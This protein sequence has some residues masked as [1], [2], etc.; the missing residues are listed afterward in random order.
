PMRCSTRIAVSPNGQHFIASGLP[1]SDDTPTVTRVY[2][3]A[4]GQPGGPDLSAN[5][6][7]LHAALAP[8]RPFAALAVNSARPVVPGITSVQLWNWRSGAAIGTPLTVPSEPRAVAFSPDVAR[9]AVVCRGGQVAMI[10]VGAWHV[11]K[12]WTY[13]NPVRAFP[14]SG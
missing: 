6:N 11:C 14:G 1:G 9:L 8:D 5:A 12:E 4:T 3:A 2:D 10:D 7:I 13:P